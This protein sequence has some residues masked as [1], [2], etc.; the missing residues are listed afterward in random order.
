MKDIEIRVKQTIA[1][2]LGIDLEHVTPEK[3]ITVDL[4]A[5]SLDEVEIVMF[6]EDEFGFDIPDEEAEE[7]K[8]VKQVVD[9]ITKRVQS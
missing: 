2:Q 3:A 4:G 8:T 7:L 5:N 9:Y 6:L 1:E